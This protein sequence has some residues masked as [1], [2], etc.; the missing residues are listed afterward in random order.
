MYAGL[1][2]GPTMCGSAVAASITAQKTTEKRCLLPPPTSSPTTGRLQMTNLRF[3][4]I[5]AFVL[6]LAAIEIYAMWMTGVL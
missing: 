1:E 3:G 4:R 2:M 5:A 6:A